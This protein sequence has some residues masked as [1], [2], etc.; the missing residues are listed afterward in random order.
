MLPTRTEKSNLVY[1]GPSPEIGDLD[2]QRI[3]PGLIRS[4]WV[5]S[6]EERDYIARGGNLELDLWAEP[7]PPIALNVTDEGA[8]L[9]DS[10]FPPVPVEDME[11]NPLAELW[12]WLRSLQRPKRDR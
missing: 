9:D 3:T 7:I 1:R 6:P 12:S 5:L 4:I 10:P 11:P 8:K 2:C